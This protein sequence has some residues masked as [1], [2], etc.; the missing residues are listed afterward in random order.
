[1]GEVVEQSYGQRVKAARTAA[2]LT[3]RDLAGLVGCD[4]SSISHL[5]H[6]RFV[7]SFDLA[8]ALGVACGADL[9]PPDKAPIARLIVAAEDVY[10]AHESYYGVA[11]EEGSPLWALGEALDALHRAVR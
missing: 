1:M 7:P 3:Q 8:E 11:V 10:H 4:F 2:G 6:G 9:M 5:E